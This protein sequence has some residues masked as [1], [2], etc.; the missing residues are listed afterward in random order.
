[1]RHD[2]LLIFEEI[3]GIACE[4]RGP[5]VQFGLVENGISTCSLISESDVLNAANSCGKHF[6]PAVMT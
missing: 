3:T 1:M 2:A 6:D 4:K 5:P